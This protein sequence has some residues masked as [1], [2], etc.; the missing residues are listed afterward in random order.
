MFSRESETLSVRDST[1]WIEAAGE[2]CV[3]FF[4]DFLF[5]IGRTAKACRDRAQ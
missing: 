2:I 3:T 4:F 1:N 5:R